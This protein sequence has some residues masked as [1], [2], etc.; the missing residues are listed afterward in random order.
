MKYFTLQLWLEAQDGRNRDNHLKYDAAFQE[1]SAQLETLRGRL[2]PEAYYF[3]ADADVHDGELMEMIIVDGS[4]PAPLSDAARPWNNRA[5]QYPVRANLT[6]LD[7]WDRFLWELSYKGIRRMVVDFPSEDPFQYHEGEGFGDWGYHELTAVNERF[8]RHEVLFRSGS[9]L[10]FE[11]ENFEV[12]VTEA[13]EKRGYSPFFKPLTDWEKSLLRRLLEPEF[14]GRNELLQQV[15][16]IQGSADTGNAENGSLRLRP[17]SETGAQIPK[18]LFGTHGQG[19]DIDGTTI[20]Y[21]LAFRS[22]KLSFLDIYKSGPE[23][24]LRHPDFSS[25]QVSLDPPQRFKSR[26]SGSE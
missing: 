20:H 26:K 23:K 3:F 25:I 15:E 14:P 17:A 16:S 5:I 6:I 10:L 24:V 22:G 12:T 13:R 7:A 9:T 19:P 18:T 8:L 21:S 11:F 1:Y 2:S 4:R